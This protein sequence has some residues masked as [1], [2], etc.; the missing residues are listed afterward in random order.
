MI[1]EVFDIK[2]FYYD[3]GDSPFRKYFVYQSNDILGYIVIDIIYDKIEIV[4]L[5]VKKEARN[6][7]IGTDMLEYVISLAKSLNAYN[8]TLEV[9]VNNKIAIKL[10]E[11]FKFKKIAIRK[12]YYKGVDGILM[13]LVI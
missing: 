9:N 5:F 7:K 10:Y 13:E 11:K 6:R 2:N 12:S 8:I 3:K 1:K 4:D